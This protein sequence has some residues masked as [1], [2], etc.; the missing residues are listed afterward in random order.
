M[1]SHLDYSRRLWVRL[2]LLLVFV[3]LYAP[4]VALVAFSFNDSKRNIV[5]QGFTLDY[6]AKAWNNAS[7]FEAFTN[8]LVIAFVST[9]VSTVIGALLALALWRFRFPFKPVAEGAVA[10]PIVIPE[11]CM[12][13][14]LLAFFSRVGWPN[15]LVWPLNLLRPSMSSEVSSFAS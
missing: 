14:A 3:F 4:I 5:W 12:G 8:S 15:D 2:W 6:Y 13:V 11:I 10:L 7:L 1:G 9:L